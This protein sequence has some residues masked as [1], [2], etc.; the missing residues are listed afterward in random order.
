MITSLPVSEPAR[1]PARGLPPTIPARTGNAQ[2]RIERY[3]LETSLAVFSPVRSIQSNGHADSL[4]KMRVSQLEPSIRLLTRA[5]DLADHELHQPGELLLWLSALADAVSRVR[6]APDLESVA[7]RVL[8]RIDAAGSKQEQVMARVDV[9][10]ALGSINLFD[11]AHR[12]LEEASM[13]EATR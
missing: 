11:D 8:R 13:E 5:L 12:K 3:L 9:A 7:T 4:H 1:R 10:R 6:A 2:D